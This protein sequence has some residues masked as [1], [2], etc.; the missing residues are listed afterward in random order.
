[1]PPS[2]AEPSPS[3]TLHVETPRS[4]SGLPLTWCASREPAPLSSL[5]PWAAVL[6]EPLPI[7]L[8][9]PAPSCAVKPPILLGSVELHA[10]LFSIHLATRLLKSLDPTSLPATAPACAQHE[11]AEAHW[12]GFPLSPLDLDSG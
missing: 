10:E 12:L 3:P 11:A 8:F 2:S 7:S 4:S 9:A 6:S 1:M 5:A